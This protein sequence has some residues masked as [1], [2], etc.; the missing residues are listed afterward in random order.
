MPD[1]K[2][3]CTF[4]LSMQQ[5]IVDFACNYASEISLLAE[6]L[7]SLDNAVLAFYSI[8]FV[9]CFALAA[10]FLPGEFKTGFPLILSPLVLDENL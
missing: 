4:V 1:S 10:A 9:F 8:I 3:L 2:H 6:F 7:L 5:M